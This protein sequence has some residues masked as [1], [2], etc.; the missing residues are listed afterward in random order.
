MTSDTP[1]QRVARKVTEI[2]WELATCPDTNEL[3]AIARE[4]DRLNGQGARLE[5]ADMAEQALKTTKDTAK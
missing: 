3:E 5:L 1:S 2:L 4:V